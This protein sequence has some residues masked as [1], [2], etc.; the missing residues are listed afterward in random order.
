MHILVENNLHGFNWND[1]DDDNDNRSFI[2]IN[3]KTTNRGPRE[4]KE[5]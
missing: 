2:I 4:Y 5:S 3:S 1:D